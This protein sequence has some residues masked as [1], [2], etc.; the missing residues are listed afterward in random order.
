MILKLSNDSY[1]IHDKVPQQI[2]STT[3]QD[4][5]II[6]RPFILTL[7]DTFVLS[8]LPSDQI[9]LAT[10]RVTRGDAFA[11]EL[12]DPSTESFKQRSRTYRDRLNLVFRRSQLQIP[13]VA[14]EVLA[15]DG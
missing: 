2:N 4:N 15:L 1:Y 14:A 13:F 6:K 7:A 8:D 5:N 12:A 10:F 9:F 11:P 3:K